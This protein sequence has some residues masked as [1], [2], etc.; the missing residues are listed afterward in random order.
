M[1][2]YR[3][4]AK[5]RSV[6]STACRPFHKPGA[7]CTARPRCWRSRRTAI[8]SSYPIEQTP[9]SG[10]ICNSTPTTDA[11]A[12]AAALPSPARAVALARA[13]AALSRNDGLNWPHCDGLELAPPPSDRRPTVRG[14][15]SSSGRRRRE[16]DPG[17]SSSSRSGRDRDREGL[18]IRALAVR[19]GV[20]RRAV[21][22]ALAVAGA[23]GEAVAGG[24]AGA[25]VGAVSGGDRRV[26]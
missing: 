26:A 9:T 10:C 24:S 8:S 14:S 22:Q 5:R 1:P 18:S 3:S 11:H 25:E 23:A 21:R 13:N 4:P 12:I 2:R 16:W 15:S 17:W 7:G 20:H 6:Q 19:H